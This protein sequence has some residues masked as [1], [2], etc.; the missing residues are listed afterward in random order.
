MAQK[1]CKLCLEEKD[2]ETKFYWS[3]GKSLPKCI[4]C[5]KAYA[6]EWTRIREENTQK[7]RKFKEAYDKI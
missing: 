1:Q 6:K 3:K 2:E 7:F 4:E 5:Q